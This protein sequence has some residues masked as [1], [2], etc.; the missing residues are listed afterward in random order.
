MRTEH[1]L[2]PK[3]AFG[4]RAVMRITRFLMQVNALCPYATAESGNRLCLDL[5][6]LVKGVS[7]CPFLDL[8]V[9][10]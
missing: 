4:M 9:T 3:H 8:S 1:F 2:T 10:S 5:Q 6:V 7:A